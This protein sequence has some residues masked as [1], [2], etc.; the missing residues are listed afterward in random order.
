[1]ATPG[2]AGKILLVDLSK[3]QTTALDTEKYEMFGGGHGM[4]GALFWEYCVAPGDWDLQDAFH[5]KNMLALMT[6]PMSGTGI[7]F[8]ARTSVSGLSPQCYPIQ[9]FCH[10]NFGGM[11]STMMKLAGW[12]G[13]AVIGKADSPVYINIVNDKVTIED[14]RTLWGLTT[15]ECQEEIW[16][17]SGVRYGEE[18]QKLDGGYTLQRPAIV[19][20]GP[21]GENLTRVASLVHGGGNGAG[22]GGFGGV[23]GSK[24]L[25]A[26]AVIGTGKIKIADPK[27]LKDAKEWWE[28]TW[29]RFAGGFGGG[30]GVSSCCVACGSRMCHNRNRI[31][32]VDSDDCAESTWYTLEDYKVPTEVNQKGTDIVQQLGLNAMETCFMGPMTFDTSHNKEFPIRPRVPAYTALGWY[33][34]KMYDMKIIGPGTKY[35][36]SPLPMDAYHSKEF[37]EI[38]GLALAKRI[39]IGNLLAE[40]TARFAEKLG[41]LPDDFDTICRLTMWGYQDHWSMPGVEWA[42]GNLMDSRDINSH[43]VSGLGRAQKYTCEQFVNILASR[44]GKND[45]FWFDYSWEGDQ[46]YKTG[47]FSKQK[48]EWTAWHQHY[49]QYYKESILYCDWGYCQLFNQGH[50]EGHGHTPEAE[51]KFLNAVTGRKHTFDDGLEIGRRSWNVKRAIFVMQGRHRKMENFTGYYYRPGASY[52]GFSAEK[53]IFDGTK[54]EWKSAKELYFTREGVEQWKTHFY[55][56][57]GWDT[58]S[59]YPTRKTLEDLRLK[60]VADL[61]QSKNKLGSA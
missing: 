60:Y 32:S 41:R 30:G 11:F 9:W 16:K 3:K 2:Y 34:K 54:W 25:K 52:C 17:R 37:M 6:G 55:N 8:A 20:M 19:T 51:P 35:D 15:W 7:H 26:V 29:P 10:S 56:V 61:L 22:Q 21:A 38:Y 39:G 53:P 57:E 14:A 33:M 12:D 24:N 49:W 59:G 1:M 47:I 18:W 13:I 45:P 43:D 50:P 31:Y 36:M 5:P 28:K 42:Y 4:A 40:G 58:N 46:A 27:G 48:A 44:T 23:M